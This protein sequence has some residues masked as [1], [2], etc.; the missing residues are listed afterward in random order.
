MAFLDKEILRLPAQ[1]SG[2][3]RNPRRR[4]SVLIFGESENDTRTISELLRALRPDFTGNIKPLREPPLLIK[5]ASPGNLPKRANVLAAIVR[6]E[7]VTSRVVCVLAHEDCDAVEPA[8]IRLSHKIES[9]FREK[10]IIAQAATP[11][12]EMEAWLF[13]WPE[14][15]KKYKPRWRR[16]DNYNGSNVGML[17]DAKEK[18]IRALRPSKVADRT[19]VRDY[20]ESDSPIIAAKIREL[21]IIDSLSATSNSYERFRDGVRNYS[22]T[23]SVFD[24][25]PDPG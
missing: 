20:R 8:H 16:P 23:E 9:L 24:S 3:G 21:E 4:N 18:Y 11:A 17:T 25:K 14:A 7:A 15:S 13:L 10:G 22:L 2:L 12:W 6:S 19:R 1:K 5:D